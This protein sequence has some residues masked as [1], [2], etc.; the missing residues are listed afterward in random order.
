[1]FILM[2]LEMRRMLSDKRF[3]IL[4]LA[5]PVF[6]YLLFTNL[7]GADQRAYGLSQ[8]VSLMIAMAAY[9][10]IGTTLMATAPRIA[11]ERTNGWLRQLKIMPIPAGQVI[12]AKVLSAMAWAVSAIVLV[13]LAAVI[14]HGVSL[15]A[16]QWLA[17]DSLLWIGTA[18]FA[19]LG[20]WI[21][22]LT[23]ESAAFGVTSGMYIFLGAAGGLWMPTSVLPSALRHI[24]VALPS[25]RFA[26]M[27]WN[28]AAGHALSASG[29]AIL[30]GWLVLFTGLAAL[31]YRRANALR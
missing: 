26:E 30:A 9:G 1:M 24:A 15:T 25:N 11:Q 10:A 27:G 19:A 8:N 6:M 21:G 14:D 4:T 13:D 2:R 29:I 3:L 23:D 16:W 22:Y 31:G 7:F 17:I 12:A 18:P 5:L 28:I 20:A